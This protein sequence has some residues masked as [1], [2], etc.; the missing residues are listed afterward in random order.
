MFTQKKYQKNFSEEGY[1]KYIFIKNGV[2]DSRTEKAAVCGRVG[3]GGG[4]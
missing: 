1:I 4:Y 3:R 2:L